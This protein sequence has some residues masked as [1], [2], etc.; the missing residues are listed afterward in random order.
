MSLPEMTCK[1]LVRR[2]HNERRY[3]THIVSS[4][5]NG[6]SKLGI[7]AILRIHNG[8]SLLY[9][10]KSL[11]ERLRQTLRGPAN[12]KILQRPEASLVIEKTA[13]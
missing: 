3:I 7:H 8:R 12:V 11:D 13:N 4:L 2:I 9:Y 1:G 6:F 10:A 5:L